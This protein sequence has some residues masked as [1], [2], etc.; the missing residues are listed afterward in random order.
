M[1]SLKLLGGDTFGPHCQH[2]LLRGHCSSKGPEER[3][4]PDG[5]PARRLSPCNLSMIVPVVL[6]CGPLWTLK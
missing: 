6:Q 3:G 1:I 2:V 4:A 5:T